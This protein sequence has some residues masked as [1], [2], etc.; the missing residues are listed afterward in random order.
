MPF[1]AVNRSIVTRAA[2]FLRGSGVCTEK[3]AALAGSS[4]VLPS[5]SMPADSSQRY[6]AAN[7]GV[8]EKRQASVGCSSDVDPLCK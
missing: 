4:A 3:V 6:F 5:A 2:H 1:R 7:A 8:D